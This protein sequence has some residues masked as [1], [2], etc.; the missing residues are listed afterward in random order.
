[1]YLL[2]GKTTIYDSSPSKMYFFFFF[3]AKA[4][5]Q[6]H[7]QKKVLP[8]SLSFS[9]RFTKNTAMKAACED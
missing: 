3:K 1:M 6:K 2:C 9:K 5:S 7:F 4:T 8:F